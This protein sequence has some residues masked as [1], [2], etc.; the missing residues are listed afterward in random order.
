MKAL[1]IIGSPRENGCTSFITGKVAQ[2]MIDSGIE[3]K[4]YV[5]GSLDIMYCK[6]CKTCYKT[7]KCIQR[8]D[9]DQ[10]INDLFESDIILV[11]APSYWGDVPGQLKVFFDR[12]TPI[13]N[14]GEGGTSVPKGKIGISVAVRAGHRQ[15]ENMHL[16]NCIEHYFGHLEIKPVERYTVERINDVSDF[17]NRK[18]ELEKAY[19]VGRNI[20]KKYDSCCL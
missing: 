7:R 15:E 16:I 8:D 11:A 9:V 5:L 13:C 3:V 19:L 1:C 2:G 10:I 18:E 12:C 20:L 17:E 14:T 6:G 4:S